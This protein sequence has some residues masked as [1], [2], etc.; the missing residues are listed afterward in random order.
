MLMADVFWEHITGPSRLQDSYRSTL[1]SFL[2]SFKEGRLAPTKERFYSYFSSLNQPYGSVP[3]R[4][5]LV[6]AQ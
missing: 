3:G 4:A 5:W 2:R 6:P 1:E